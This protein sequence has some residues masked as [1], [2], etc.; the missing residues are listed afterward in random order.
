L[1]HCSTEWGFLRRGVVQGADD[2]NVHAVRKW[3]NKVSG[4]K[5]GVSPTVNECVPQINADSLDNVSEFI[6]VTG[7]GNMIK[8]HGVILPNARRSSCA[9]PK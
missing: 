6:A 7:V 5:R 2:L 1:R 3:K 8:T 9:T 4:T